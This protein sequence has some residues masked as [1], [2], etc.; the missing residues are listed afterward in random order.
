MSVQLWSLSVTLL[1]L[2]FQIGTNVGLSLDLPISHAETKYPI[3]QHHGTVME[4]IIPISLSLSFDYSSDN[5]AKRKLWEVKTLEDYRLKQCE[6]NGKYWEQC[7]FYGTEPR[8][9][10]NK[11][12]EPKATIN[13]KEFDAAFAKP[14]PVNLFSTFKETAGG[15]SNEMRPP[16]W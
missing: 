1:L 10:M 7:F 6:E 13:K 12:E 2:N 14:N 3:P 5:N 15:G 16:T 4:R 11:R 8:S 9:A